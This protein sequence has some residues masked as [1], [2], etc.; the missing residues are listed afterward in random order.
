MSDPT[1]LPP[2]CEE[3]MRYGRPPCCEPEPD[4]DPRSGPTPDQIEA[5]QRAMLGCTV[6]DLL[7]AVAEA[8]ARGRTPL[9]LA[10]SWLSDAQE[11]LALADQFFDQGRR[12]SLQAARL[13]INRAK[14]VMLDVAGANADWVTRERVIRERER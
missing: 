6:P 10:V 13:L 1:P 2:C 3:N 11:H 9:A 5:R 4:P 12:G 8:E 14:W 7:L